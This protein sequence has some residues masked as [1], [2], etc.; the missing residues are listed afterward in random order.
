MS[1][2][3]PPPELAPFGLRAMATVARAA[4][5]GIGR[6]ERAMLEATQRVLLGTELA[7]DGLEE[8]GP[9]ELAARF[10]DPA[11]AKQ[12]VRGMLLLSLADGP[13]APQQTALIHAYAEALGVE[14]GFVGT[15]DHLAN[16]ELLRFRLDFYRRTHLREYMQTHY[17]TQG[18]ILGVAKALLGTAGL[19]EDHALA[20]R[21]R[22]FGALPEDSLG[23]AFYR[24]YEDNGFSFPGERRGFPVGALWHDFG[25]VLGGYDT[26]PEGELQVSA[27]Q[28]GY[29]RNE[30]ALAVL[31]FAMLIH[32]AGVNVAPIDMPIWV[33]RIGQPGLADRILRAFRRGAE[34]DTDLG[35]DWDFWPYVELPIE[36]VRSRLGVPPA[37]EQAL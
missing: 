8:I 29:R 25:H 26:S 37:E 20:A 13:P 28:S 7:I 31:F 6:P 12:L 33:G 4:H 32:T 16:K 3:I 15:L 36:E 30:D 17:R 5:R 21:F 2:I 27:F 1:L 22:A 23:Y 34:M 14:E 9:A 24:H 35:D 11:L 10:A 18:G 19:L